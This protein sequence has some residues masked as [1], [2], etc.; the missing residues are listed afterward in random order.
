MAVLKTFRSARVL[1]SGCLSSV[2]E[3]VTPYFAAALLG[4]SY[5]GIAI[6]TSVAANLIE[7]FGGTPRH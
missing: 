5:L 3:A 1:V 2:T 6:A 7:Y 4:T